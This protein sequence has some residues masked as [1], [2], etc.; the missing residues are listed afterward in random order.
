MVAINTARGDDMEDPR[1]RWRGQVGPLLRM[2]NIQARR[3][4]RAGVHVQTTVVTTV[5]IVHTLHRGFGHYSE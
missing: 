2:R 1:Q 4:M 5:S 3:M